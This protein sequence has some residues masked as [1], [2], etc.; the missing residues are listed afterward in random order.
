[1]SSDFSDNSELKITVDQ[2]NARN[3]VFEVIYE[4]IEVSS[5][6]IRRRNFNIFLLLEN[7]LTV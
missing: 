6:V 3:G 5:G 4:V 1:M 2:S 7:K